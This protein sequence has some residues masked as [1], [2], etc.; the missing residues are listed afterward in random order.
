MSSTEDFH[1]TGCT[2]YFLRAMYTVRYKMS[3]LNQGNE[4]GYYDLSKRLREI[5]S[6]KM[7]VC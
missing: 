4:K 2:G 5:V 6:K 1:K 7:R 3:H